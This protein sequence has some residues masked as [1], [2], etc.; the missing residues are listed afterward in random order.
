MIFLFLESVC[1][2][3]YDFACGST[4]NVFLSTIQL[5]FLVNQ[6]QEHYFL[7][8]YKFTLSYK[9]FLFILEWFFT[10]V[11]SSFFIL[12]SYSFFVFFLSFFLSLYIVSVIII[13]FLWWFSNCGILS[14][15]ILVCF[16][17][18][19]SVV[20]LIWLWSSNSLTSLRML[21]SYHLNSVGREQISTWDTWPKLYKTKMD[22][23]SFF[24][25]INAS[26]IRSR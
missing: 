26:K 19:I 22:E 24:H 18:G 20:I 4:I 1:K 12:S 21:W 10:L 5:Y 23:K 14:I 7:I 8:I 13:E 16:F 25:H 2:S 9:G 3:Y 11:L 15:D 6:E 17:L